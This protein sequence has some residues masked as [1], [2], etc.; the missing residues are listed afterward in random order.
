MLIKLTYDTALNTTIN[1]T[2]QH[3]TKF[4]TNVHQSFKMS[5]EIFIA[6]GKE[7]VWETGQ[8]NLSKSLCLKSWNFLL[9][10]IEL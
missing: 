5:N 3:I 6:K 4:A 2:P 1:T 10:Y 9:S 8:Q 7:K